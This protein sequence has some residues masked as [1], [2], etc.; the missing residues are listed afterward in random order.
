MPEPA[1]NEENGCGSFPEAVLRTVHD[2]ERKL[3]QSIKKTDTRAKRHAA[4]YVVGLAGSSR[5][6][7][8]ASCRC[9]V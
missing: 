2:A 6:A 8:S 1:G 5:Q 9:A 4:E 7:E 3:P